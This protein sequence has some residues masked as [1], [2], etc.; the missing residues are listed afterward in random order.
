MEHM[1]ILLG[2]K[3]EVTGDEEEIASLDIMYDKNKY[4]IMFNV[5][6]DG[7][8]NLLFHVALPDQA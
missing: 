6:E 8:Y 3:Q 2:N 4:E 1:T 7:L 5:P